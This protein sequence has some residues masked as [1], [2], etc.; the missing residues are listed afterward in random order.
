MGIE[1]STGRLT[2]KELKTLYMPRVDCHL[3][4]GC[5]VCPDSE[6][7]HVK[8]LCVIQIDFLRQI[9]NVHSHSMLAPLFTETGIIPLRIRRFILLLGY[10]QYL[11]SLS[12]SHLARTCLI[13]SIEL[14]AKEKKTWAGDVLIAA[15][16]LP[17]A[18]PPLD[19]ASATEKTVEAYQKDV[20]ARALG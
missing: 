4:H 7:I 13:S 10:L 19:S 6:D 16:K 17:F 5:E 2:P 11:L 9:L 12:P 3:I 1:D 8:E 14:A 20:V 18:C 15:S